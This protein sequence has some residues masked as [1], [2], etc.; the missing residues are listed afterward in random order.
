MSPHAPGAVRERSPGRAA[1]PSRVAATP[2][3]ADARLFP[4]LRELT[5]PLGPWLLPLL[6]VVA[7]RLIGAML[8]PFAS[9][10]AYITYRYARN[11]AVGNGLEYNPGE[12]VMGFTSMPWTLW[13]AL[14][15]L[16][17][18][19]PV[20][21]SRATSLVA[22]VLVVLVLGRLLAL[23]AGRW[24][25]TAFNV[26]F[27]C[28]PYFTV[29]SA[30]GMEMNA[31][32]SALVLAAG[33][34]QARRPAGAGAALALAATL[35]P[36]GL[37]AGLVLAV[38]MPWRARLIAA[39]GVAA[40]AAGT[41]AWFGTVLPQSVGTK[42]TLYGT[43]GPW[44]GRHW[45]EWLSPVP[46]GRWPEIGDTNHMLTLTVVLAPAVA[47]G[48]R[49]LWTVRRTPLAGVA[50]ATL[51]V[52]LGY[53]LLGIAYFWWYF[54]VPLAGVITVAAVGLP[55]M[56]RGPAL[57]IGAAL[58]M[59]G[60]WVMVPPLYL[61]RADNERRFAV[62]ATYL[63]GHAKPGEQVMLEP[64][65][66]IGYFTPLRVMDEVGLVSPEVTKRRTQGG[67]GW[68]WDLAVQHRPEWLVVR[69]SMLQTGTAFAGAGAPFR[70]LGERD[71]LLAR[72]T[73]VLP[74]AGAAAQDLSVYRRVR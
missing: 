18:R 39:G 15:Y 31:F 33:L 55:R 64:I 68:Y 16:A 23:H 1:S 57:P 43:H 52:W 38:W 7:S 41:W 14:G 36:E 22:D 11:L 67:P 6:L 29:V 65:G 25:A 49:H 70:D 62:I 8:L 13:N 3:P 24:S 54:A 53:S 26:Y 9:E 37:A 50:A 60:M 48:L 74:E 69:E 40:V 61:G 42:A 66:L 32:L 27:A 28:W 47:V 58:A 45:W 35:R 56:V 34:A 72:Y 30:S 10:D 73:R 21:W 51:T 4:T 2:T 12:R 5:D 44:A 71:S 19:D 63:D 17:L 20:L 59:L 46:M